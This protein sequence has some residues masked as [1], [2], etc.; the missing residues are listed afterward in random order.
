MIPVETLISEYQPEAEAVDL[1]RK[2]KIVIF[3]GITGAGKDAVQDIIARSD[4]F[5]RLITSTTRAR[6]LNGGVMEQDGK[7]YYFLSREH[8]IDMVRNKDYFEVAYVHG[9]I[10]GATVREIRRIHDSG[11]T[12][13]CD[14]N[15]QGVEYYKKHAPGAIAIFLIPPSFEVWL[16]RL[17]KRYDSDSEFNQAWPKRR[18]SAI[19][20]L[21]WA[22]R[23]SAC[24]IV[25]NDDLQECVKASQRI[26]EGD[27]FP[28]GGRQQA[29]KILEHLLES[30]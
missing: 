10:N 11:K 1:L 30:D 23:S 9:E 7:E 18:H 16:E 21:T 22:L 5:S 14:V 28:T 15:Y 3:C 2:T 6:R 25:V 17:R 19:D 12:A 13:I 20:E 29:E 26:I 27:V 4:T 8:A 24:R